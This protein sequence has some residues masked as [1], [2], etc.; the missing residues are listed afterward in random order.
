M[1]KV[2]FVFSIYNNKL[3]KRFIVNR[4][5]YLKHAIKYRPLVDIANLRNRCADSTNVKKLFAVIPTFNAT[6]MIK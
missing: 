6:Q 5:K 4:F 3:L 2:Q 1:A